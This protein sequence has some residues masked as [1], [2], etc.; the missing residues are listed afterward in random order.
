LL[1]VPVAAKA[2]ALRRVV[3][4][5]ADAR[6]WPPAS[7]LEQCLSRCHSSSFCEYKDASPQEI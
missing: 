4:V 5:A 1:R 3:G 7:V 6:A 2:R